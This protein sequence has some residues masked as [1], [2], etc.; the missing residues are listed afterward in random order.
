MQTSTGA[1][2][3]PASTPTG[4]SFT[5]SLLTSVFPIPTTT[6]PFNINVPMSVTYEGNQISNLP[7]KVVNVVVVFVAGNGVESAG[8]S[9]TTNLGSAYGTEQR[10]GLGTYSTSYGSTYGRETN[11][12]GAARGWNSTTS[13]VSALSPTA[14][15]GILLKGSPC[16]ADIMGVHCS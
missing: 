2:V 6:G 13:I 14:S 4:D 3:S 10:K 12:A 5:L 8:S 9:S 15:S 11:G 16:T 1:A 7:G